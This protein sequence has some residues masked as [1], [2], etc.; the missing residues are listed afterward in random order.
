ML[1]TFILGILAGAGAPYA[2]PKIKEFLD[3]VLSNETPIQPGE[4]KLFTLALCLVGAAILSM[5][6]G[7]PH[8]LPLTLGGAAG[9]FGPRLIDKYKASKAP[10]YDS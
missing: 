8:A 6:F 2:E 7:D 3:R 5:V 9:V 4:M 10:D 1:G